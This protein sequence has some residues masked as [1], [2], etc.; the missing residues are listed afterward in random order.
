MISLHELVP[1]ATN[2]AAPGRIW[3]CHFGANQLLPLYPQEARAVRGS[4]TLENVPLVSLM[5]LQG[6]REM[7]P[8]VP[9][10]G[11]KAPGQEREVGAPLRE[12]L[13]EL[14]LGLPT[15]P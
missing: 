4:T 8:Y 3:E 12:L 2:W 13:G 7:V 6:M 10:D 15:Y 5:M 9:E 14:N 1:P 11:E